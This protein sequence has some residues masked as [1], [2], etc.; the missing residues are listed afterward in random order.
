M[1]A[2]ASP[3]RAEA[4]R[5][6]AR[7]STG[8]RSPEGKARSSRNALS[9]GLTARADVLVPGEDVETYDAFRAGLLA[10]LAPEGELEQFH[11]QRAAWLAWRL[12][13]IPRIEAAVLT[14]A[15]AME[16]RSDARDDI[17]E[18]RDRTLFTSPEAVARALANGMGPP[19]GLAYARRLRDDLAARAPEHA[20]AA[21]LTAAQRRRAAAKQ[22]TGR[23]VVKYVD[24][25]AQALVDG[26]TR[27][28]AAQARLRAEAAF[29]GRAFASGAERGLWDCLGRYERGIAREFE[30]AV[31]ALRAEQR[32]RASGTG[33]GRPEGCETNPTAPRAPLAAGDRR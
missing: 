23:F 16:E 15:R 1:K 20:A 18:A 8:P 13:R 25:G 9:H 6:N 4:N 33:T 22:A 5:A 17:E 26:A 29:S 21:K 30:R 7:L 2:Q 27:F 10:T 19:E 24:K 12:S 14:A 31:E 3:A 32:R 11:A 28:D